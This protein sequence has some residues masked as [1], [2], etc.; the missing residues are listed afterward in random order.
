MLHVSLSGSALLLLLLF[1]TS[2]KEKLIHR[3]HKWFRFRKNV[4]KM[5]KSKLNENIKII[6]VD[7]KCIREKSSFIP[8]LK[9]KVILKLVGV[10]KKTCAV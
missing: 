9:N 2:V 7:L 3:K 8:T 1:L 10:K 6:S 5:N 4:N